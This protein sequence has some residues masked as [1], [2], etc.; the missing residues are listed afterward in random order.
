MTG[1]MRIRTVNVEFLRPG[2]AHNQLLSPITQYLAVCNNSGAGVV[3][4][5]RAV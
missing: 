5:P 3:T 2:P 4:V 1:D